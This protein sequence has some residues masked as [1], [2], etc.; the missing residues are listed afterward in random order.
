MTLD[1]SNNLSFIIKTTGEI[2]PA[3]PDDEQFS[4]SQLRDYV[5]GPPEV[6]CKTR[7]GFFLFHNKEGKARGLVYPTDQIWRRPPRLWTRG[8]DVVRDRQ[9]DDVRVQA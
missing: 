5:A 4:Q 8:R 3:M 7:D 9:R 6:V 2:I 1:R